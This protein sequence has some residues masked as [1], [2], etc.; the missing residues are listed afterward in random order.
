MPASSVSPSTSTRPASNLGPDRADLLAEVALAERVRF[1]VH[2]PRPDT[3][4]QITGLPAR[5]HALARVTDNIDALRAE[6]DRQGSHVQVGLGFVS[7]PANLTQISDIADFAAALG[8]DFLDVRKDEVDVT[9]A[10]SP[11]EVRTLAGQVA[12]L[13][14]RALA[15]D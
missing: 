10:L 5:L 2:S 7:Q 12:S 14:R 8:V 13:R 4:D 15:G 6:R 11:D 9:A 1:S 3:Y